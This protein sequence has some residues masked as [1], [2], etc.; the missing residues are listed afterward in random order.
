MSVLSSRTSTGKSSRLLAC[1]E[2][3]MT[4][5]FLQ[6]QPEK[7][8]ARLLAHT[9]TPAIVFLGSEDPVTDRFLADYQRRETV[10]VVPIDGADHFFRDLYM[11]ELIE[12]LLDWLP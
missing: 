11:D 4:K 3:S 10:T 12:T 6:R 8:S 7:N 9:D 1:A 2:L 5:R